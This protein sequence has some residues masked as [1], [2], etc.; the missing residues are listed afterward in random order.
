MT[1][2]IAVLIGVSVFIISQY[3]LKLVLEPITRV[4]RAVA[5]IS[6]TVLF[7]QRKI[8]NAVPSSEIAEELRRVSSQLWGSISEVRC[9]SFWSRLRVFGLPTKSNAR[10]ACRCLNLMAGSAN[11]QSNERSKLVDRNSEALDE[12]GKILKI[13][14]RYWPF[15][16]YRPDFIRVIRA[17][18]GLHRNHAADTAAATVSYLLPV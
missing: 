16:H 13:E 12:L 11:D 6:S 4:R 5:D 18:C 10:S 17:I 9:Y 2:L 3:F 7:R 8:S 14:T 1:S 15:V